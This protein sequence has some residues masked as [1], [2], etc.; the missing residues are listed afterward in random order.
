[1]LLVMLAVAV[2]AQAVH[3]MALA[4]PLAALVLKVIAEVILGIVAALLVAA[5]WGV[6]AG[7]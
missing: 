3:F 5:V 2:V 7:M 4:Q 1:M 6:Q